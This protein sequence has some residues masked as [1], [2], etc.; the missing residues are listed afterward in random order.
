M[1]KSGYKLVKTNEG[2]ENYHYKS[3]KLMRESLSSPLHPMDLSRI[4]HTSKN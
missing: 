3:L 4:K 2:H 1:T